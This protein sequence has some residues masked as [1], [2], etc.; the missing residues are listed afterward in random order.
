M[1]ATFTDILYE[2]CYYCDVTKK[3]HSKLK[4]AA[5]L[6]AGTIALGSI[7]WVTFANG[8]KMQ[9]PTSEVAKVL[10]G[11]TFYTKDNIRVRLADVDTPEIGRCGSEEAKKMLKDLVTNRQIYVKTKSIDPFYRDDAL[12]YTSEGLVNLK[13]LQT[14][15][16]IYYPKHHAVVEFR[17]AS[18]KAREL[19]KGIFGAKC[20]QVVNSKRPACNIKGNINDNTGKDVRNYYVPGCQN[21]PL[22]LVEL[23]KGDQWF[24]TETEAIKAGFKKPKLCQ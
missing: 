22:T 5:G 8:V 24:C 13:M 7:L 4:M 3:K 10:D 15:M 23:Y 16:G 14:G 11:D 20:T 2:I 1:S 9:V 6:A 17:E 19:K 12:V 21:Y 18:Q